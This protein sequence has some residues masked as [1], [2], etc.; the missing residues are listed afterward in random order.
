MIFLERK[1]KSNF[2]RGKKNTNT[3][4]FWW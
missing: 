3:R 4:L 2:W 1:R